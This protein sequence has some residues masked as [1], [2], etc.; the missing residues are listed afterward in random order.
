MT[1][2]S[3]AAGFK[4]NTDLKSGVKCKNRQWCDYFDI[5]DGTVDKSECKCWADCF[6]DWDIWQIIPLYSYDRTC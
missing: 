5:L 1:K 3:K 4:V 2:I 6:N